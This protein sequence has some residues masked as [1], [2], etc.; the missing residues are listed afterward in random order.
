MKLK[1]MPI[2]KKTALFLTLSSSSM[3]IFGNNTFAAKDEVGFLTPQI[4]TSGLAAI[5]NCLGY[6]VIGTEIRMTMTL[7]G[8]KFFATPIVR[9]YSPDFVV[10]SQNHNG[11]QPWVEY[12]MLLAQPFRIV[13]SVAANIIMPGIIEVGGGQS[14]FTNY[15]ATQSLNFKEADVVGNPLVILTHILHNFK[16]SPKKISSITGE[17]VDPS[18]TNS[19]SG[20][21]LNSGGALASWNQCTGDLSACASNAAHQGMDKIADMILKQLIA[22]IGIPDIFFDA[23]KVYDIYMQ[24]K[25]GQELLA[26]IKDIQSVLQFS[27]LGFGIVADYYACPNQ[28]MPFMPAYSSSVDALTYRSSWPINDPLALIEI[29][30]GLTEFAAGAGTVIQ[31]SNSSLDS[32][33]SWGLMYPRSG[34]I[35]HDVDY[36][37]GTVIA[38]RAVDIV[39]NG[40]AHAM[41]PHIS[42]N[43]GL[44]RKSSK[45]GYQLLHPRSTTSCN[46][47]IANTISASDNNSRGNYAWQAWQQYQCPLSKKGILISRI[48]FAP[49]CITKEPS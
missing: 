17:T 4:I 3:V 21:G 7:K 11:H 2:F 29:G 40:A 26:L 39:T 15:G 47:N 48:M 45:I 44:K 19:G 9:H 33:G 14:Q 30:S 23:M 46:L 43:P 35:N 22:A 12:N 41:S 13:Q 32:L 31:P 20:S 5:P 37:I 8:P 18:A 16:W 27:G 1:F 24:L 34:F 49:I 6:C 10:M 25:A 36:K 38:A 28:V 42:L